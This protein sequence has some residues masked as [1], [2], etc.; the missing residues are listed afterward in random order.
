METYLDIETIT[1][2]NS[3]LRLTDALRQTAANVHIFAFSPS[4]QH[5]PEQIFVPFS[6]FC[7]GESLMQ[8]K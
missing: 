7:S 6:T 1:H 5:C 3:L 8:G 2:G 4:G